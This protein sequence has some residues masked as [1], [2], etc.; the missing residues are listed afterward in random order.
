MLERMKVPETE[1]SA[2]EGEEIPK[3]LEAKIGEECRRYQEA[4]WEEVD[5][6]TAEKLRQADADI[7][8]REAMVSKA[9]ESIENERETQEQML[10]EFR[11]GLGGGGGR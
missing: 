9:R 7:R 5:P 6:A 10:R 11:A 4:L 2:E 1:G 8:H 3:S